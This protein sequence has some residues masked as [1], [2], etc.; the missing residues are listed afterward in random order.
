MF[1]C[2]G[3][4]IGHAAPYEESNHRKLFKIGSERSFKDDAQGERRRTWSDHE[5]DKE[6]I[7]TRKPIKGRIIFQDG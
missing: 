4:D 3:S 5:R 2:I 6:E 1:D 7:A